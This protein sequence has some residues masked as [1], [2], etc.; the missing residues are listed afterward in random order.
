MADPSLDIQKAVITALRA[1]VGVQAL[2]GNPARVY[3]AVPSATTPYPMVTYGADQAISD[4]FDCIN[5]FEVFV[6]LDVW[7]RAVGQPEAKR[8][9]GAVR[10]VLHDADL[11]LDEHALVLL[12]HRN[13]RYLKDPDGKTSHAVVE[14]RALVDGPP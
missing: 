2:V 10:G 13:T 1:D 7:S 14:F 3:D 9:A 4:D 8:I 6:T 12:E 5:S 11:E